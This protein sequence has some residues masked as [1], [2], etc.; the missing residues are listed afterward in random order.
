MN[1]HGMAVKVTE[2]TEEVLNVLHTGRATPGYI[3]EQTDLSRQTVHSQ[4]N[5]LLAGEHVVYVHEGTGLYEL[6]D[7]PREGYSVDADD[8]RA[9]LQDAHELRDQAQ[10]QAHQLEAELEDCR[11]QL[12]DARAASAVDGN[13]EDAKDDLGRALDTR[14]W[15]AVEDA[16]ARLGVDDG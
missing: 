1:E 8:L 16:A 13:V 3:V 10:A 15:S 9:R 5:Q 11:E 4:L 7:D 14:E 6:R 12:A 2:S